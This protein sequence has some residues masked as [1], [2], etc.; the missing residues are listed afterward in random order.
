GNRYFFL[1]GLDIGRK[2]DL[3]RYYILGIAQRVYTEP[4]LN[5]NYQNIINAIANPKIY[6]RIKGFMLIRAILNIA[7]SSR[8][9][10]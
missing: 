2:R 1:K 9:S 3:G 8:I 10:Y 7:L 4:I 6:Y 5:K